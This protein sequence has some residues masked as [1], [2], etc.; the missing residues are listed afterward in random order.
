MH[1]QVTFHPDNPF[2]PM[3]VHNTCEISGGGGGEDRWESRRGF[4]AGNK[5]FHGEFSEKGGDPV[6][7]KAGFGKSESVGKMKPAT[8]FQNQVG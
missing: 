8:E 6:W 5:H 4:M 2:L 3:K 7:V 1:A